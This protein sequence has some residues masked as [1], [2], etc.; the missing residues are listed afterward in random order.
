MGAQLQEWLCRNAQHV[1]RRHRQ[2]ELRRYL[3]EEGDLDAAQA[4]IA[5]AL[6]VAPYDPVALNGQAWL[7]AWYRRD[8]LG[9]AEQMARR[10]VDGAKGDFEKARYL[11]TLG[12]VYIQQER[13]EEAVEILEEAAALA[14]VD[15][16]VVYKEIV[17]HL[18]EAREASGG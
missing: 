8:Q 4:D 1:R 5:S 3:A 2:S 18:E 7:Y 6:N 10:A 14:T 16:E 17:E 11:H 9:Q 12:W 15:G 13:Y